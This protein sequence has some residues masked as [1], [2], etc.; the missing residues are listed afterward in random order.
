MTQFHLAVAVFLIT[1]QG[2]AV[3]T[4][5]R[6]KSRSQLRRAATLRYEGNSNPNILDKVDGTSGEISVMGNW[7]SLFAKLSFSFS[8]VPTSPYKQSSE[9]RFLASQRWTHTKKAMQE[10]KS[11]SIS[12][13]DYSLQLQLVEM[14]MMD[15][16]VMDFNLHHPHHRHA[17][18]IASHIRRLSTQPAIIS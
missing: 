7:T 2:S 16:I 17:V 3:Q 8:K 13:T 10:E 4:I 6:V 1:H 18:H 12:R 15:S 5:K 14:I 11:R 9:F